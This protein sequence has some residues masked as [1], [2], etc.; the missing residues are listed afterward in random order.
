VRAVRGVRAI[1]QKKLY[2]ARIGTLEELPS[3]PSPLTATCAAEAAE[4][5][6]FCRDIKREPTRRLVPS[7][8]LHLSRKP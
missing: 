5:P 3:P 7:S 2:Y 1:L 8:K 4:R 6:G